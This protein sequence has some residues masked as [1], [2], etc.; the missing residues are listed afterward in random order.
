MKSSVGSLE[1]INVLVVE[2][3]AVLR[4]LIGAAVDD[5]GF[6][7]TLAENLAEALILTKGDPPNVIVTDLFEGPRSGLDF[8]SVLHLHRAWPSVPIILCTARLGA[9][10]IDP[11]EH[12]LF[13]VM[14]KPFDLREFLDTIQRAATR[15]QQAADASA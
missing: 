9:E 6:R 5:V 7:P 4:D 10:H 1:T 8:T 15:R 13:A 3:D 14:P 11:A 12:D 2:D